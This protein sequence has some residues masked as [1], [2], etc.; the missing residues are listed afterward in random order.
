MGHDTNLDAAEDDATDA[1][2]IGEMLEGGEAALISLYRR[3]RRDVYRFALG[4]GKSPSLADDVVQDVFLN[5]I[6]NA[7]RFDPGKGTVRAW[8]LG[9]ARHVVV[10]HLRRARR[11]SNEVPEQADTQATDERVLAGQLSDRLHAA[12]ARLPIEFREALVLYEL[13]GLSYE[14]TAS[15]LQCPVGTVRS[16]LYRARAMLERLFARADTGTPAGIAVAATLDP[17]GVSP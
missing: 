17:R 4:M 15:V 8:L 5:V 6:Q 10:D 1:A 13:Q 16:R 11:W 2:L 3:R 7:A 12:I 9:C 14:E